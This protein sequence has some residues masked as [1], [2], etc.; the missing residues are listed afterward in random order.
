MSFVHLH[1]HS[2]YSLLDGACRIDGLMERVKVEPVYTYREA[3]NLILA[4]FSD[5]ADRSY[6]MKPVRS[7][8]PAMR[9][10]SSFRTSGNVDL[11]AD[12]G[13]DPGGLG[14]LIKIDTA[15]HDAVVGNGNGTLAQFLHPLHQAVNAASPIQEAVFT[16]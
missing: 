3:R 14:G 5:S 9:S 16:M 1:L 12:D 11:A 13:L 8:V 2:E 6:A 4:A 10:T 15:V 7:P